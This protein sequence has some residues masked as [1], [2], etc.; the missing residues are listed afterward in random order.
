MKKINQSLIHQMILPLAIVSI[1]T[2]SIVNVVQPIQV[3]AAKTKA[4]KNNS[5]S[6]MS[7]V[8]R[9]I[10]SYNQMIKLYYDRVTIQGIKSKPTKSLYVKGPSAGSSVS[11]PNSY[12]G[13]A[14]SVLAIAN[15][16]TTKD[17]FSDAD[18][19]NNLNV[20]TTYDEI[21]YN[22]LNDFKKMF[23]SQ[24]SA[25][26]YKMVVSKSEAATKAQPNG[27]D[28]TPF[29]NSLNAQKD[30]FFALAK[31]IAKVK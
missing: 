24:L 8:N 23:K 3:S 4:Q 18:P 10:N 2:G 27:V 29:E 30:A 20:F 6:G 26:E 14:Q 25:S 7:K 17:E 12:K 11:Y 31:A 16:M 21:N 9:Y 15:F 13:I 19:E 5:L 1:T 22:L 28:K